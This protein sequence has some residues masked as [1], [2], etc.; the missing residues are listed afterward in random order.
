MPQHSVFEEGKIGDRCD[1]DEP[2]VRQ[3]REE[4]VVA[5][6]DGGEG[7]VCEALGLFEAVVLR[8]CYKDVEKEWCNLHV[9]LFLSESQKIFYFV[10]GDV[11]VRQDTR[12]KVKILMVPNMLMQSMGLRRRVYCHVLYVR[13]LWVFSY[14]TTATST[15]STSF[16]VIYYDLTVLAAVLYNMIQ[17]R[18]FQTLRICFILIPF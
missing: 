13:Y 2:V 1:R 9:G 5:I 7:G 4:E 17:M 18:T 6:V 14:C 16:F 11:D 10:R 15:P 12:I 3:G 8:R